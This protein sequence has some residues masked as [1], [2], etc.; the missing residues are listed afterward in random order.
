MF[1]LYDV[2]LCYVCVGLLER[3]GGRGVGTAVQADRLHHEVGHDRGGPGIVPQQGKLR[4]C[5][6]YSYLI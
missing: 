5:D 4:Y 1:R 2:K 3:G 6:K